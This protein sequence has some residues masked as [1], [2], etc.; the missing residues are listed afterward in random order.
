MNKLLDDKVELTIEDLR[1]IYLEGKLRSI[2]ELEIENNE[3]DFH[4]ALSFE[5]FL[6]HIHSISIINKTQAQIK[7][8]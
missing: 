2:E 1:N 3:R 6:Y 7:S 5:D 8:S 4:D